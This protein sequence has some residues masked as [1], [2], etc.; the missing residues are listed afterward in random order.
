MRLLLIPRLECTAHA[1]EHRRSRL[2][3]QLLFWRTMVSRGIYGLS[4]GVSALGN[5]QSHA[6]RRSVAVFHGG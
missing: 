4:A 3:L 6:Q 1:D 2:L 5:D